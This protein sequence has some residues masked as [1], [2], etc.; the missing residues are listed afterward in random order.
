M[1]GRR[2]L[3]FWVDF[4]FGIFLS[5]MGLYFLRMEV[6]HGMDPDDSASPLTSWARSPIHPLSLALGL[7]LYFFLF[8]GI[9]SETPGLTVFGLTVV[10]DVEESERRPIGFRKALSRTIAL[11]FSALTLGLGFFLAFLNDRRRSLH[12]CL[13]G[14]RVIRA[15]TILHSRTSDLS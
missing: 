1:I 7:F 8:L 13:S 3:A 15:R 6:L 2:I 11:S 9:T 12:D 4:Y 14:T 5:E 10:R